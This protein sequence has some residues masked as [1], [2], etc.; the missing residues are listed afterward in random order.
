MLLEAAKIPFEVVESGIDEI[1]M[2]GEGASSFALRMARGKALSVANRFPQA[3][4]LG[5]DTVVECCGEIMGKPAD[6]AEARRMLMALSG[7]THTVV[8]AF[9]IARDR[10]LVESEAITSY[11]TFREI[12]G[13]EIE[14]Y[15]A[16]GE[17]FDKAGSYGIQGMG[18]AFISDVKGPRDNV[19]GL[20]VNE[21]TAALKRYGLIPNG[22]SIS[23]G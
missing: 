11:V 21:V 4:V 7:R 10:A 9:A 14:A 8:T 12:P 22:T 17:P 18:A 5:A 23:R 6:P 2:D 16:T 19:M 13:E 15:L 1:R 3:I 20:P